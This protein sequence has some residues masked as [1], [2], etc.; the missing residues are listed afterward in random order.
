[1]FDHW[2]VVTYRKIARLV[3][4]LTAV[5]LGV[6]FFYVAPPGFFR[7]SMDG[8][9][10]DRER[11]VEG[12]PAQLAEV[13]GTVLVK[14]VGRLDWIPAREV[15]ELMSGDLVQTQANSSAK[16]V[17]FD[18]SASVLRADSI[19]TIV[20]SHVTH[21]QVRAVTME[22]SSGAV[23]LA[24]VA[25]SDP[26][27]E[28][29]LITPDAEARLEAFAEVEAEYVPETRQSSFYVFSGAASVLTR[30]ESPTAFAVRA[31][32][33]IRIQAGERM[34]V[35]DYSLPLPPRLLLPDNAAVFAGGR[36][37]IELQWSLVDG[38]DAYRVKV[39][40]AVETGTPI[41]AERVQR[42][43]FVLSGLEN[44]VYF[45]QVDSIGED[46]RASRSR[47]SFK[48]A[49]VEEASARRDFTLAIEVEEVVRLGEIYQVVG[50]TDPG[51]ALEINN[52]V[53]QVDGNGR[54]RH[55]T[56]RLPRGTDS[57]EI[58]AR[59]LSGITRTLNY[60]LSRPQ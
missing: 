12:R 36:G 52:E 19:A 27:D 17:F 4:I 5:V 37:E 29:R 20:E 3:L 35:E 31:G 51:V 56:S 6:V 34:H 1:M 50:R 49:L 47:Q 48:F 55:F 30:E 54:F 7:L 18:G 44:G 21:E 22:I 60:P 39:F 33:G 26:R 25:K 13:T 45:W 58:K 43:S 23:D 2:V 53:V 24:T 11:S 41:I 28:T 9:G 16:V 42:T 40:R 57:L 46:G 59:D 10:P 14:K 32:Q 8:L 15:N 38:V